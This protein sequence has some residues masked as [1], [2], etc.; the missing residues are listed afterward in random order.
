M[1]N[2]VV[3]CSFLIFAAK[4]E[5]PKK[6]AGD[7]DAPVP[8]KDDDPDGSKLLNTKTPLEDALKFVQVL[9]QRADKR[10]E[11]WFATFEIAIRQS[12]CTRRCGA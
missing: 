1:L 3:K 5:E 9:Q 7:E 6:P 2:A 11:T 10:I 4:V 12:A 8:P